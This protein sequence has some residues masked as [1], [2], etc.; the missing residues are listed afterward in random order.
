MNTTKTSSSQKTVRKDILRTKRRLGLGYGGIAGLSFAIANWGLDALLLSQ[1]HMFHPW[2]KLIVAIIV[3]IPVGAMTGWLASRV[4]NTFF[5]LLIWLAAGGFFA[6]LSVANTFQL[7]PSLLG[8]L[9]PEIQ[10]FQ[11]YSVSDIL[12][13]NGTMAYIWMSIFWGII[14]LLQ[15]PLLERATFSL[16]IFSK[17]TPL[18]V[19]LVLV[20][21]GGLFI[22][23]MN[24][25][26][27]RNSVI[28]LDETV[29]F[30]VD[31]QG[32][33]IDKDLSRK[34]RQASLRTVQDWL[35]S[36]RYYFIGS[37][38]DYLGQIN[39]MV[40][41]GGNIAEC[42]VVYNQTSFCQPASR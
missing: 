25:E 16:S 3:C 40:N 7:Y 13:T 39:V 38:D 24:N 19:C 41:F 37:F 22:D 35:D 8:K 26:P 34:M 32:Q 1:V 2:L 33:E 11:N 31:T 27:L 4:D 5:S 23:N 14:G 30:A 21:I 36:P 20:L 15:I 9:N 6:W 29:Q 42:T 10:A 18:T 12:E 28:A 17:L